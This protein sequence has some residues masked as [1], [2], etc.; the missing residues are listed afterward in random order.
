MKVVIKD[1]KLKASLE[2]QAVCQ[3]QYGKE[4]AKK[5]MLRMAALAAAESLADLWPPMSGPERC[6]GLRG[7][8]AGKFSV[9]VKQP[10]RLLFR[11]TDAPTAVGQDGDE[12]Q[13][14]QSINSIEIL[15]IEDIHG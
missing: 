4:M 11:P 3:R 15:G 14:W 13:R 12:K 6:H 5:V 10:Y 9:D 8:M 2:D 7:D 1:K